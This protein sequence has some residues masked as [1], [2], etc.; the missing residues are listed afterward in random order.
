MKHAIVIP[1]NLESNRLPRK[2]LL[3]AEGCPLAAHTFNRAIAVDNKDNVYIATSD[4]VVVDVFKGIT[5]NII[6]NPSTTMRCGSER[7][8]RALG[9]SRLDKYDAIINWQVDEPQLSGDHIK[10]VLDLLNSHA[11]IATVASHGTYG[12][13]STNCVKVVMNCAGNALY[14]SR[15]PIPYCSREQP[16]SWFNHV[17]IYGFKRQTLLKLYAPLIETWLDKAEGLEQ[18]RWLEL[19]YNIAVGIGPDGG[20]AINTRSDFDLFCDH[21]RTKKKWLR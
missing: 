15:N 18:L 11:D 5:D 16:R 6:F 2:P 7:V 1:I 13:D 17:G 12:Y 10:V 20:I 21:L 14:F 4:R 19:G 9:D 3:M 8:C